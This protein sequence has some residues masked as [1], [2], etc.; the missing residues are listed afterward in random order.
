VKKYAFTLIELVFA[1]IIISVVVISLPT[2]LK[3]NENAIMNNVNQ[4]ALFAASA[5]MMQTLTYPWDE[6]ASD[7]TNAYGKVVDIT[8]GNNAYIRKD[9]NGTVDTNS[10]FRVGHIQEDNHRRFHD[11]SVVNHLESAI[12][13]ASTTT[14]L[15]NAGKSNVVFDNSGSSRAGYK[16]DYNMSIDV[17]FVSDTNTTSPD[18][19]LF[20]TFSTTATNASN[21][22]LISVT[23]K[24]KSG[25]P[26]TRLR[27][28]SANIG[29]FDF[30]KRRF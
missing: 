8:S 27:A 11:V 30:A 6:N 25:N 17:S 9:A 28:Y 10:S 13:S 21:M 16:Q 3:S 29:E 12:S 1:I 23:I 26:I 7:S 19:T 2:M 4:E 14:A 15:N 24:D 18:G 5:E 20:Y 22:K